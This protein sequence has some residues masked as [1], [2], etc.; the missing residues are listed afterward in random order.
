MPVEN[1]VALL[2][3]LNYAGVA[4][5]GRGEE[6]L[7]RLDQ[8]YALSESKGDA[9]QIPA[10]Y[11]A[12]RFDQY[13]FDDSGH[14]AAIDRLAGKK[15]AAL[16]VWVRDS[17]PD[18]TVTDEKVDA[19]ITGIFEYALSKDVNVI[20]YPHYNTYYQTVEEFL[21]L[22]KKINHPSCQIA[23]NLCH[24]LMSDKGDRLKETF[25][26]AKGHIGA[27]I[28]SGSLIELDRT[29]VGTTNASTILP[30]D[31]SVYDLRPFMRLIKESGFDGPIGF[32]NFRLPNPEDYLARSMARWEALCEEVDL[33]E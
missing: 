14:R 27:V 26:M 20:L 18:G 16:W 19:F 30:L 1:A 8:Y 10:A 22:V 31:K 25:A 4:V 9:F 24:E 23:I 32:I 17:K 5:E 28:L 3:R 11:M 12:H 2:E 33:Y 21:P 13:G 15:D 6:S 29:N 7:A